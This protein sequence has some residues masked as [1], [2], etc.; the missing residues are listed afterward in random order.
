MA[1]KSF[2]PLTPSLRFTILNVDSELSKKRPESRLTEASRKSGGRNCHGRAT[3]FRRG[4]GH[5][6][7]YRMVDF[8]RDKLDIPGIV[9]A[10]FLLNL[11][12]LKGVDASKRA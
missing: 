7:R 1:L 11:K 2:R 5:K 6:R 8:R 3:A 9:Q 12:I 4:G 10:E